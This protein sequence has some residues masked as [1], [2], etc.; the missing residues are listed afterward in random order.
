MASGECF[1]W[2][3]KCQSNLNDTLPVELEDLR[4]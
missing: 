3:C 4:D 2:K 1:G